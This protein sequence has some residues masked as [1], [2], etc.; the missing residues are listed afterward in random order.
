MQYKGR[1]HEKFEEDDILQN[2]DYNIDIKYGKITYNLW[3]KYAY[4]CIYL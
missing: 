3:K 1:K 2:T 4:Y